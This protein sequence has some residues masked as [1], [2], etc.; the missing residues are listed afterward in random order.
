MDR[1]GSD[2]LEMNEEKWTRPGRTDAAQH[3][4]RHTGRDKR[5]REVGII[6]NEEGTK[7]LKEL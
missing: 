4:F 6:F 7:A 5:E 1:M 3:T 2:V